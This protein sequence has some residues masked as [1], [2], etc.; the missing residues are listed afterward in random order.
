[1]PASPERERLASPF[2]DLSVRYYNTGG[3][4]VEWNIAR[5]FTEPGPHSFQL[6]GATGPVSTADWQPIGL[7]ATNVYFLLDDETRLF[8]MSDDWYYRIKLTTPVRTHYSRILSSQ[9]NLS[10]R[11]WRL[12]DDMIRKERLRLEN[13][14]G[15]DVVFLKRKR[16]GTR[17]PECTEPLTGDVLNSN[18]ETCRG[19]GLVAGYFAGVPAYVEIP[20]GQ[21][22]ERM[23]NLA[24]AGQ[25][26]DVVY[27]NCR[28][29]GEPTIDVYDVFVDEGSGV[30]Y[31][32]R[33]L[34]EVGVIR[35]YPIVST[36]TLRRLQFTDAAYSVPL[37]G[38]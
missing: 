22:N 36:C 35:G 21:N 38:L 17:C 2:E 24:A 6:E 32:V 12:A 20:P 9:D 28:I 16:A 19:T 34:Q 10:F 29:L 26:N 30:R 33:N 27:P 31:V 8:G 25:T 5:Q 3:T 23:D 15:T 1:M 13:Y 7:A 37:E 14:V 4:K 18:C 11:D